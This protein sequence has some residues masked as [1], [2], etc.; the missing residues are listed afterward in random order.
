MRLVAKIAHGAGDKASERAVRAAVE[1]HGNEMAALIDDR[2]AAVRVESA[3]LAAALI[4]I[5]HTTVM[6]RIIDRLAI[7]TEPS[8]LLALATIPVGKPSK[9][10]RAT[11]EG[12]YAKPATRWIGAVA[13]AGATPAAIEQLVSMLRDPAPYTKV[14]TSWPWGTGDVVADV[15][16][17]LASLKKRAP[18]E[19][20]LDVVDHTGSP[21]VVTAVLSAN[22]APRC[23]GG[24][25]TTTSRASAGR[26]WRSTG[27][28]SSTTGTRC[29][30]RSVCRASWSSI[31]R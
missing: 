23:C 2:D 8:V 21:A 26:R 24:S 30:P 16:S 13:L 22:K 18:I 4:A 29:G 9:A 3:R 10:W 12:L 28:A 11:C 17:I 25:S 7:E 14:W 1:A 6:T 15:A 20:M 5:G 27:Q 31:A 19:A